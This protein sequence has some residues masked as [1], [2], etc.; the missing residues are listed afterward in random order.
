[1]SVNARRVIDA[2]RAIVITGPVARAAVTLLSI[3][4]RI[5]LG[6]HFSWYAARAAGMVAYLLATASVILG[7]ATSSR[8]GG[9]IV[10]K[11]SIA[12]IHRVLSLLTLFAICGHLLFLALDQYAAF[13]SS[14]LLVPFIGWY[15]PVWSGLGIIAA[16]PAVGVYFSFYLRPLIGYKTWRAFH[17]AAFGVF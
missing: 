2:V 4:T 5:E 13:T 11:G 1:M 9:R 8:L 12:D 14:D 15:R 17:Y 16:Y 7:L 6:G 10:G 3:A